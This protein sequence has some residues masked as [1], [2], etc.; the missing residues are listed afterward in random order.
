MSADSLPSSVTAVARACASRFPLAQAVESD[1]PDLFSLSLI[2]G[3]DQVARSVIDRLLKHAASPTN[4]ALIL[5]TAVDWYLAADPFR[6]AAV[7][8]T[9]TQ[10][11]AMGVEA[12]AA[13]FHAHVALLGFATNRFNES[14]MRREAEYIIAL[15]H[16]ITMKD[17]RDTNGVASAVRA[18]YGALAQI[19]Y[20]ESPDSIT[21]VVTKAKEDLSRFPVYDEYTKASLRKIRDDLL[22]FNGA[23]YE[24]KPL[25]PISAHYW[26]P[27][28]PTSWPP[29]EGR[30]AL[31]IYGGSIANTCARSDM[32][33]LV[34]PLRTDYGCAELYTALSRWTK[35]YGDQ[36]SVTIISQSEGHAARSIKLSENAEADSLGWFFRDQLKLP[37]T[38]G[39]VTDSLW[40][41]PD[42]DGRTFGVDTTFYGHFWGPANPRFE[43]ELVVLLYDDHGA[44]RYV[45]GMQVPL[46]QRLIARLFAASSV[47]SH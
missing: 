44:L 7:E 9:M 41:L 15:S 33:I 14:Y 21:S 17:V 29:D 30:P 34:L 27:K 42:I 37:V 26:I 5:Q 4:R 23:Q 11:D 36:F 10:L 38:V 39:L 43:S 1:L 32:A 35:Q 16:R 46:L 28:A 13:Q 40:K 47:S 3:N 25:P 22:P 31:V 24:G 8:S 2:A 45:G 20:V 12:Q 18:S 19:A 6:V